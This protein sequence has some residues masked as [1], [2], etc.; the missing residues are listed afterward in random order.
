[1]ESRTHGLGWAAGF[2]KG[3]GYIGF[4][5]QNI[6]G[7]NYPRLKFNV[8]QVFR[9]P[10]DKLQEVLGVGKVRGPYGPYTN[11]RQPH[12]QYNISGPLAV[13]AL[14]KIL[15]YLFQKGDQARKAIQ[16]YKDYTFGREN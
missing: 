5:D 3:E 16:Q 12:Y 13:E 9:E 1:M 2:V 10:L 8:V 11:N 15:L 4:V 14:E 6:G 7:K